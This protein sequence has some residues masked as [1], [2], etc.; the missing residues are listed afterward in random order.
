MYTLVFPLCPVQSAKILACIYKS[1]LVFFC[2]RI[3]LSLINDEQ[4]AL[5]IV[6]AIIFVFIEVT[7]TTVVIEDAK[8]GLAK[9]NWGLKNG[10]GHSRCVRCLDC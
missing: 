3:H 4:R 1:L 7:F 9:I 10:I 5:G 2:A 6:A 8:N